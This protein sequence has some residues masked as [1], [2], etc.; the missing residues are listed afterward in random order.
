[1]AQTHP[2]TD[3]EIDHDALIQQ[4]AQTLPADAIFADISS[5]FKLLGDGTR[6]KIIYALYESELRV[7]DIVA[8]LNM[9]QSSVSH[10]LRL[11]RQADLVKARRSGQEM[12]YSL[13]DDHIMTIFK[14]VLEHINE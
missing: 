1:M 4:V 10:Q 9:S 14:Q 13:A 7:Y 6:A 11:L 12:Y 5:L 8:V 3:T 2:V